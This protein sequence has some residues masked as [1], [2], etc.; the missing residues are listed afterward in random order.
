MWHFVLEDRYLRRNPHLVPPD[1]RVAVSETPGAAPCYPISQALPRFNDFDRLNH[2]TSACSTMVF[3][4]ASFGSPYVPGS[5]PTLNNITDGVSASFRVPEFGVWCFVSEPVHNL[6]HREV[7]WP[8]G[9]TFTSRRPDR[10]KESEFLASRDNWFRPTTI[11]TGPDGGLWIADMYRLVIEHPQYIPKE[12][13]DDWDLRAGDDRG[14]IYRVLFKDPQRLLPGRALAEEPGRVGPAGA[15]RPA[16]RGVHVPERLDRLSTEELVK[17]LHSP[18]GWRRDTAQRLLIERGDAAAVGSLEELASSAWRGLTRLHALYTLRRLDALKPALTMSA[19]GHPEAGIRRH[20]VRLAEDFIRGESGDAELGRAVAALADDPDPQVRTQVAYTLGEWKDPAAGEALAKIALRDADDPYITTAVLSSL[21]ADNVEAVL[22]RALASA[23]R[24]EP[25]SRLLDRLVEQASLLGSMKMLAR[26]LAAV[27]RES[28]GK[29]AAWQ[30]TATAR[31]LESLRRRGLSDGELYETDDAERRRVLSRIGEIVASARET[32][33][34]ESASIELRLAA[35][36][37]VPQMDDRQAAVERLAVLLEPGQ[38]GELQAA[39]ID[40]LGRIEDSQRRSGSQVAGA[41]LTAWRSLTPPLRS[42]ALDVLLSRE[43][44]TRSLLKTIED[45]HVA[46]SEI[47]ASRR[48]RLLAHRTA[49]I[50]EQAEKLLASR[51]DA[52]RQK[53]VEEYAGALDLAGDAAR[54]RQVFEKRCASCHKLQGIGKEVGPDLA[55]LEDK[56]P[57]SLLTAILD[58]NRAV[59]AKYVNYTAVTKEGRQFSGMLSSEAGNAIVLVGADGNRVEL[60]RGDLEE[61]A[62]SGKSA[63]PEGLEKD[64]SP[65]DV[66]DAI[67]FI[68]G[69]AP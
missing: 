29:P 4:D 24:D 59:E 42:R 12:Q 38:A 30:F 26:T 20:A 11:K 16:S 56:S 34:D 19:L 13:W 68:R 58:P 5:L 66:A 67:A 57:K 69:P 50:R 23:K 17:A 53:V 60:V 36:D 49:G 15:A 39:A 14:R 47:D 61:L 64:L 41:L 37:L 43:V 28:E 22:T 27:T 48:Q 46:H 55:A 45:G 25:T 6:V 65:Q 54:G 3:R 51:I 52:D 33:A 35:V 62:G 9:V 44:W 10:E 32:A 8:K 1:P 18:N 31:L 21:H 7:M 63:M 2:F 40:S